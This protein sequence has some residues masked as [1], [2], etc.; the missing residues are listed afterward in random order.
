MKT[1]RKVVKAKYSSRRHGEGEDKTLGEL[2][3]NLKVAA[4]KWEYPVKMDVMKV[5]IRGE[6]KV[7]FAALEKELIEDLVYEDPR[8]KERFT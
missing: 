3:D 2:R 6:L 1:K 5:L 7:L 8:N 4:L